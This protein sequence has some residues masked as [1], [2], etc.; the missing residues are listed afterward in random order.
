MQYLSNDQ[1]KLY[2]LI[3]SR[4]IASQMADARF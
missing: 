3:Y 1:Y 2:K 4:F